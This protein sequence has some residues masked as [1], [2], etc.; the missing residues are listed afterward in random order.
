[1][2]CKKHILYQKISSRYS[3]RTVSTIVILTKLLALQLAPTYKGSNLHAFL[4]KVLVLD[5]VILPHK[6]RELASR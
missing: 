1:M 4:N 6:Y 5:Q 2:K 3:N